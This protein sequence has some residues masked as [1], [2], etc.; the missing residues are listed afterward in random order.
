MHLMC[1]GDASMTKPDQ[2]PEPTSPEQPAG[3]EERREAVSALITRL[4]SDPAPRDEYHFD[5]PFRA[6]RRAI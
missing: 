3:T 6:R 4:E 1:C 2:I 5:G